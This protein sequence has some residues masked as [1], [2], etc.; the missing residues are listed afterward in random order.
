MNLPASSSTEGQYDF[1]FF[2]PPPI[3]DHDA[4]L[5][6]LINLQ[7]NESCSLSS[8]LII[9]PTLYIECFKQAQNKSYDSKEY[10]K[11]KLIA[12]TL[13]NHTAEFGGALLWGD[14]LSKALEG[15][16]LNENQLHLIEHAPATTFIENSFGELLKN[17]IDESILGYY[18]EGLSCEL[19]L[20]LSFALSEDHHV[21]FILQ[22]TGRGFPAA[23]LDELSTRERQL[24]YLT[25][26]HTSVKKMEQIHLNTPPLF[27]GRGLGLRT[28]IAKILLHSELGEMSKLEQIYEQSE[29]SEI[30]F[31][32]GKT[33]GSIIQIR[34]STEPLKEHIYQPAT[35]PEFELEMPSSI[36]SNK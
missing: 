13:F 25:Q 1:L 24:G 18:E 27:G 23:L 10:L 4:L 21:T 36:F 14:L 29:I 9:N 2:P 12:E 16:E 30:E 31:R 6:S 20:Q 33:T 7:K 11:Y 35:P 8:T 28:L 22:D 26:R 5:P 32:R 19:R 17:L 34:T 15:S 3:P